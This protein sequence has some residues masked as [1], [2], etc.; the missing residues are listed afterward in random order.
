MA[1]HIN[2][3]FA[4]LSKA[5]VESFVPH[6]HLFKG[7]APPPVNYE[8]AAAVARLDELTTVGRLVLF[9]NIYLLC[10][11]IAGALQHP[12]L[13]LVIMGLLFAG[14]KL[15][16]CCAWIENDWAV[17]EHSKYPSSISTTSDRQEQPIQ[18]TFM[19]QI[20]EVP[21][22]VSTIIFDDSDSDSDSD[23]EFYQ[24]NKDELETEQKSK[25]ASEKKASS[26][27]EQIPT[28][29][30]SNTN[31]DDDNVGGDDNEH[32]IGDWHDDDADPEVSSS[33]PS[34]HGS[35]GK[36]RLVKI[37]IQLLRKRQHKRAHRAEPDARN[38]ADEFADLNAMI[39]LLTEGK[40]LHS[41]DDF[42]YKNR[43][44][45]M[46][47]DSENRNC[48]MQGLTNIFFQRYGMSTHFM[49]D[50]NTAHG[51]FVRGLSG[52]YMPPMQTELQAWE[53]N[54]YSYEYRWYFLT[55]NDATDTIRIND[56]T[57]YP[58][59]Y[60]QGFRKLATGEL[61]DEVV[62]VRADLSNEESCDS[63]EQMIEW[64]SPAAYESYEE[65]LRA[66]QE[67]VAPCIWNDHLIDR[68]GWDY[69]AHLPE[70]EE[71]DLEQN[72]AGQDA[73]VDDLD[74]L[75][76]LQNVD[77]PEPIANVLAKQFAFDSAYGSGGRH[78]PERIE[79]YRH[80]KHLQYC[81]PLLFTNL[82]PR[83]QRVSP[84]IAI[85][86]TMDQSNGGV[87]PHVHRVPS[88]PMFEITVS[89]NE[90]TF[91]INFDRCETNQFTRGLVDILQGLAQQSG[92]VSDSQDP[93]VAF[94]AASQDEPRTGVASRG[95]TPNSIYQ[96]SEQTSKDT[97]ADTSASPNSTAS[98]LSSNHTRSS[99]YGSLLKNVSQIKDIRHKQLE[100][101]ELTPASEAAQGR[102]VPPSYDQDVET[103]GLEEC[104]SNLVSSKLNVAEF[105]S[106]RATKWAPSGCLTYD[107]SENIGFHWGYLDMGNWVRY[108]QAFL[109]RNN[110]AIAEIWDELP[111]EQAECTI[112][113]TDRDL[114]YV[115]HVVGKGFDLDLIAHALYYG[116]V[117][118]KDAFVEWTQLPYKVRVPWVET[119]GTLEEAY[120]KAELLVKQ[121]RMV[122]A[123]SCGSEGFM[124]KEAEEELNKDSLDRFWHDCSSYGEDYH[125][126]EPKDY[127]KEFGEAKIDYIR[128]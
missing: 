96:S 37:N 97:A 114:F 38:L 61:G 24:D 110:S 106:A 98:T 12:V 77:S 101:E 65:L 123:A 51:N 46:R 116:E 104:N 90:Q 68:R 54:K 5:I 118:I 52:R 41:I 102:I 79:R 81:K 16:T 40:Y 115:R 32:Q 94:R 109:E 18:F 105:C 117:D 19:G 95:H 57:C 30:R 78:A 1:A 99:L 74:G 34:V 62:K 72:L 13:H 29:G 10:Y 112:Q 44:N 87:E 11:L 80:D 22:N 60:V 124:T 59:E 71:D 26:T 63:F 111:D 92:A 39:Q 75:D 36:H 125:E 128:D 69:K 53:L 122:R 55:Q 56:T 28:P 76:A 47:V 89:H 35:D 73:V 119:V 84:F 82:C 93:E 127:D 3:L 49:E 66:S 45:W 48:L 43:A 108:E 121:F 27:E 33:N 23:T 113:L 64:S 2:A 107:V 8:V 120:T 7:A 9:L 15:S 21:S 88:A 100:L 91:S 85:A 83:R 42:L 6:L 126:H 67:P 20:H 14:P 31:D 4:E 50:I 17:T 25:P 58:L 103:P 86:G 70:D